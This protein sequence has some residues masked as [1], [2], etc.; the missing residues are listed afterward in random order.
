[1]VSAIFHHCFLY[2]RT[3]ICSLADLLL[4][5]KKNLGRDSVTLQVFDSN[6]IILSREKQ[7]RC[8]WKKKVGTAWIIF[9][10]ENEMN[11]KTFVLCQSQLIWLPGVCMNCWFMGF[12]ACACVRTWESSVNPDLKAKIFN[13]HFLVEMAFKS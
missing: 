9:M 3:S 10:K 8:L 13:L 5:Y 12:L 11:V 7:R 1:M 6:V 4:Q 2:Y